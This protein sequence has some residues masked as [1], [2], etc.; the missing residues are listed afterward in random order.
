M[1][2]ELAGVCSDLPR[3]E[4]DELFVKETVK[5]EATQCQETG[6][7]NRRAASL[8]TKP[9]AQLLLSPQR[10]LP[11]RLKGAQVRCGRAWYDAPQG[12]SNRDSSGASPVAQA[13]PPET[14]LAAEI[15]E[16]GADF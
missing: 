16:K 6:V 15:T 1:W 4:R 9:G 13:Q 3:K 8:P 10:M 5:K 11:R 14:R 7:L 12:L 2:E